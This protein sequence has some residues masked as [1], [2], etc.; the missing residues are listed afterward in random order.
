[1]AV[2]AGVP[3]VPVVIRGTRS[4]LRGDERFVRRGSVSLSAAP[5]IH[6]E[7]TGWH[8]GVQLRDRVRAAILEGCGE[9]DLA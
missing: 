9:P 6:P 4:I 1:V 3:V 7:G 2:D 8:A 5:P